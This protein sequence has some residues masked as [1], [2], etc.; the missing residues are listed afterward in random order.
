MGVELEA[1][2]KN[3]GDGQLGH[4]VVCNNKITSASNDAK[5]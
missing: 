5:Y 2:Y 4:S 1:F 3:R